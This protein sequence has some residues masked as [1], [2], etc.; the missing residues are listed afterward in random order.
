MGLRVLAK[1]GALIIKCFD[2]TEQPTLDL[3]WLISRA[4]RTW[5]VMKPRSSRAGNA[6]RY[7]VGKGFL[8]DVDD[9]LH[10]LEYYQEHGAVH[11]F[12][13]PMIVQPVE[14]YKPMLTALASLQEQIEHVEIAVIRDTIDLIKIT[15]PAVI[16]CFVRANVLRS[17][18]WCKEHKED[19]APHW[20]SDFEKHL[21]KE[22]QDLLHILNP[23][24]QTVSYSSWG[25]R[26]S[27]MSHHLTF[28]GFRDGTLTATPPEHN[29]FM[30]LKRGVPLF[31]ST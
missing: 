11:G 26:T 31:T 17:L 29:P 27:T 7:I 18:D 8:G 30:R 23:P 20:T 10:V 6:E 16:K 14:D 19:I 3:I 9:I 21:H 15:D 1:G 25:P 28:D 22:T 13:A 4:F 24:V 2:T 5:G 12:T